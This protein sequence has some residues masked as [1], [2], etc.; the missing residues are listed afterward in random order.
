MVDYRI[1]LGILR[2]RPDG[3]DAYERTD[4]IVRAEI[5]V[6]LYHV[7]EKFFCKFRP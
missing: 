5:L 3:T 7:T 4:V 2:Y 1:A 6:Y